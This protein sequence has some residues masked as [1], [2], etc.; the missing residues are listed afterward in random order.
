VEAIRGL[1]GATDIIERIDDVVNSKEESACCRVWVWMENVA[2]LARR[3]RLDIEEPIEVDS[4]L[5]H[6]PELG[7]EDDPPAR[8]GPLK[9]LRYD[10]LL[11]LDR[12]L[13]FSDSP[14]SS[15][16]S[17]VSYHSDV[18]GMPS[19]VSSTPACPTTW[20]YRWHL[21]FE[22]GTFPAPAAR[23]PVH[24][25]LRF[26]EDRDGDG[27]GGSGSGGDQGHQQSRNYAANQARSGQ[28]SRGGGS[29]SIQRSGVGTYH[30]QL[31]A[32]EV[33]PTVG[34]DGP[35]ASDLAR[36]RQ[37][38][39]GAEEQTEQAVACMPN[40]L[41]D[42]LMSDQSTPVGRSPIGKEAKEMQAEDGALHGLAEQAS[43]GWGTL[44]EDGSA[45]GTDKGE[46]VSLPGSTAERESSDGGGMLFGP[47]SPRS[48]LGQAEDE[49]IVEDAYED[50]SKDGPTA[51]QEETQDE[52]DPLSSFLVSFSRPS[53]QALLP[54]PP[55]PP[56]TLRAS[57][58]F[59]SSKG[60]E[61]GNRSTRLAAKPTAGWSA[62]EKVQ[63]VLLKKS[64]MVIEET[65]PQAADLHK[66]RKMYTKPLP[67]T[68]IDAVTELVE[69][70]VGVKIKP[71]ELSLLTA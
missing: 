36:G 11:H 65:S 40:L 62:M 19:E 6:F 38:L 28:P 21:G 39:A 53:E 26:P 44:A 2:S 17:H 54:P 56:S 51:D 34:H 67:P 70:S 47:H 25:R 15:P 63:M 37:P 24:S 55:P 27:N 14:P 10:I 8:T 30:R 4:P 68:F 7:M 60:A 48:I 42:D 31:A 66:Y 61:G 20:G 49:P 23:A 5:F 22:A 52:V 43:H 57:E 1:F 59:P 64:G 35:T 16:D 41:D 29:S 13:D 71:T 50:G 69:T 18:S 33:G 12:V 9:T 46:H 58:K 3:G 45:S 32:L